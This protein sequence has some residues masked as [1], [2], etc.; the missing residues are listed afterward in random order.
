MN[1]NLIFAKLFDLID[2]WKLI[3]LVTI[4][5]ALRTAVMHICNFFINF[6]ELKFAFDEC[7]ELRRAMGLCI[8]ILGVRKV[9][10]YT[11][12]KVAA[13]I[14]VKVAAYTYIK[15]ATY[16]Y[17]KVAAYT[18][19]KVATYTYI[20]VASYTYIKVAEYKYIKSISIY[21]YYSS[22]IYLY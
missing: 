16:T 7:W 1:E 9:A 22:S 2:W 15:V 20:K 4:V 13:Y 17:I 21:I 5:T 10:A 12:I 8:Y 19:I 18:C 14:Y 3:F 11:Y 6:A